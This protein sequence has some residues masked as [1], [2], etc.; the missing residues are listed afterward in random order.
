MS[1]DLVQFDGEK[2]LKKSKIPIAYGC[3]DRGG[4]MVKRKTKKFWKD[5][6]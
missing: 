2:I 5:I 3:P 6:L 4:N 1:F